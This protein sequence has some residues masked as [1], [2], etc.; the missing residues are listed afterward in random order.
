MYEG[1]FNILIRLNTFMD[2]LKDHVRKNLQPNDTES[3][4]RNLQDGFV[5]R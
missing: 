3:L 4:L 2:V 5:R 1:K